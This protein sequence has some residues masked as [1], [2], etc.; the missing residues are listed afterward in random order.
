MGSEIVIDTLWGAGWGTV[1]DV[2]R[3][4]IVD[5]REGRPHSNNKDIDSKE[6]DWEPA[7]DI[8]GAGQDVVAERGAG[9]EQNR[10]RFRLKRVKSEQR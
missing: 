1:G 9:D 5:F 7:Q 3:G 6:T 10:V 8:Y 2:R 4:Y